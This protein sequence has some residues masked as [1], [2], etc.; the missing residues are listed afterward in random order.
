MDL[1]NLIVSVLSNLGGMA[2]VATVVSY[3]LKT[4]LSQQLARNLEHF[5][6]DLARD[7][8]QHKA[9]LRRVGFEHETRFSRLH[10][11]RIE[12]VAELYKRLTRAKASFE[13]LGSRGPPPQPTW[14][15][16][17]KNALWSLVPGDVLARREMEKD[18]HEMAINALLDFCDYFDENQ[19]WFDASFVRVIKAFQDQLW[20]VAAGFF[21]LES[22]MQVE[23]GPHSWDEMRRIVERDVAQLHQQIESLLR[24][25]LGV[26]GLSGLQV[27]E[28]G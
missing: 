2:V 19:F 28:E 21:I 3:V 18:E 7:L 14:L 23:D 1:T 4:A 11:R 16:R 17:A 25:L 20:G 9:E 12:V 15:G 6:A 26:E 8:E 5:R 24:T 10:E 27:A 13:R 22:G